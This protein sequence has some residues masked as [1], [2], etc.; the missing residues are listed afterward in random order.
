MPHIRI[1]LS[2]PGDV[3]EERQ[4]AREELHNLAA[5]PLLRNK[6]EIEVVS[7]D[8]PRAPAPMLATLTPQEAIG[9]HLKQSGECDLTIVV[10]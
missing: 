10:L 2:S 9:R 7:W 5:D 4:A 1:F 8:D 3:A 6:I